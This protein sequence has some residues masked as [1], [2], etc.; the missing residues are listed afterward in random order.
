MPS[1]H[2]CIYSLQAA[3]SS[4]ILVFIKSDFQQIGLLTKKTAVGSLNR[5]TALTPLFSQINDFT[6]AFMNRL[7]KCHDAVF[8]VWAMMMAQMAK[9]KTRSIDQRIVD[10]KSPS[11]CVTNNGNKHVALGSNIIE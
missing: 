1:N 10:N 8:L 2:E 3:V 11:A 4:N 7:Q 5:G 6:L 9:T